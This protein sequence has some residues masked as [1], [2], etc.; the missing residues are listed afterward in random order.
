MPRPYSILVLEDDPF[1]SL[2]MEMIVGDVAPS[3]ARVLVTA[4][5]AEA[6]EYL[7]SVDVAVL[8]ID[9][10]DGK[11][12]PI[13][14]ILAEKGRPFV[15]VSGSRPEEL[16]PTLRTAPFIPKPYEPE[17]IEIALRAMIGAG[18]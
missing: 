13:A 8:D 1:V 10:A 6:A 9:V 4:S 15:F 7:E 18:A 3:D 5:V 17:A 11:S 12:F 2:E 16:P 14:E